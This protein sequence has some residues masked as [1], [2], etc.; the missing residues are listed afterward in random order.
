MK[1]SLIAV[2]ADV[3]DGLVEK[4]EACSG[5]LIH[6]CSNGCPLRRPAAGAAE[7]IIARCYARNVQVGQDPV[8]DSS[9]V[10][11][12]GRGSLVTTVKTVR[13]ILVR[14]LIDYD[15]ESTASRLG[16]SEIVLEI[17]KRSFVPCNFTLVRPRRRMRARVA[18]E[19]GKA[20]VGRMQLGPAH[21]C[22]QRIAGRVRGR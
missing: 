16:G 18:A 19:L 11:D 9:V 10:G 14:W 6:N 13:A 15:A 21:A 5:L 20:V 8:E 7:A 1:C 17:T 4:S 2:L 12:I 3:V 22:D